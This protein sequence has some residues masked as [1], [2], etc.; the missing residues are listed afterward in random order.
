MIV[1]EKIDFQKE[2]SE[3][4]RDLMIRE[5][6]FKANMELMEASYRAN[7]ELQQQ[8]VDANMSYGRR[9]GLFE[10]LLRWAFKR[11]MIR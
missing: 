7:M 1:L 3:M 8:Q 11:R 9:K 4:K 6:L 5:E 2:E 10:R